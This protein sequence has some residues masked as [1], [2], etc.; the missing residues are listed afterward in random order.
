M[1]PPPQL[2]DPAEVGAAGGVL[3]RVQN[4]GSGDVMAALRWCRQGRHPDE[5]P[6]H[7]YH[8]SRPVFLE[9]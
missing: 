3:G 6:T 1:I 4:L 9:P 5:F 2:P 7:Q 8:L